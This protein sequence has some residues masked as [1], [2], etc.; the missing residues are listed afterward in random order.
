MK[1]VSL[2]S[3][4]SGNATL[5]SDGSTNLLIDCGMS[6]KALEKALTEAGSSI[7]EIDAILL[8]H[9]HSD[10][11]KGVGVLSRKYA[12]PIYAT[13]KTH[14]SIV[15]VGEI[16]DKLKININTDEDFEIGT[17]GVAPFSIHHDAADPV[18]YSFFSGDDKYTI[19]TDTGYISRGLLEK[20]KGSKAIIL[21]SNHD[22]EMLRC[23][24]Y[25]FYLQQRILSDY[26]HL[27]NEVAARAALEL[28]KD[29]TE[30]IMLGHLSDKNNLPEIALLETH[31]TLTDAGV[32][33]GADVTLQVA[34]RSAITAMEL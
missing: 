14:A 8:T 9:E 10:H 26:G 17:I 29:G 28:V 3:G 33:V 19:A 20:L 11:V 2:I 21:E 1:F 5:I 25:P 6:G 34:H 23:G 27:S 22:V 4:S 13:A 12:F 15:K 7:R 30:H 16:D 24:P 18:G 32:K 31:K